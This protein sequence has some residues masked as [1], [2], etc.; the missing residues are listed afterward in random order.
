MQLTRP[1]VTPPIALVRG[2][3]PAL[4]AAR[5]APPSR[6]LAPL[7]ASASAAPSTNEQRWQQQV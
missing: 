6:R 1:C 5:S 3:A 7:R 2:G 4:R